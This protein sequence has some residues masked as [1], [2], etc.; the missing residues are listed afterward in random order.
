MMAERSAGQLGVSR[1]SEQLFERVMTYH[2]Q[3]G[4]NVDRSTLQA[5]EDGLVKEAQALIDIEGKPTPGTNRRIPCLPH[6]KLRP[7]FKPTRA[8]PT[9]TRAG[10]SP[11]PIEHPAE[12]HAAED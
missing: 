6:A 12:P 11:K 8:A 3:I 9:T 7:L 5:L 1:V 2:A 4:A 10:P